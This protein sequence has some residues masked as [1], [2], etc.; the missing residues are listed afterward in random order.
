VLADELI[1]S[2]EA[3]VRNLLAGR[4]RLSR[5]GAKSP[6]V[7][8]CPDS[9][10]HPAVLP[11]I[12]RGFGFELIILWRGYGGA[13]WPAGDTVRWRAPDGESVTVYHLAR[14]G[15]ELGASLPPDA[16]TA[17][18]RW[19]EIEA[20]VGARATTSVVLLPNGADHHARQ[21][22]LDGALGAL[23]TA[24]PEHDI[25]SSSLNAFTSDLLTAA[26]SLPLP[27]IS[28]ELRDSS[29]YTWSL[30]G[31]FATR[32]AQKR[33]NAA[34][35][36]ALVREA[37]PFAAVD[38]LL[39]QRS[40]APIVRAAW[41]TLLEAHPHD[42]LCGCSIDEVA[43]AVD[44]LFASALAQATGVR[45]EAIAS[46]L[47]QDA[48]VARARP[49]AWTPSVIVRNG[50]PRAR[51]GVAVI[52]I[53]SKMADEPVGPGSSPPLDDPEVAARPRATVPGVLAIE[54]LG[55][56]MDRERLEFARHYP[57][58][59]RVSVTQAAAWVENVPG[60]GVRV[61]PI[62]ATRPR[63]GQVPNPVVSGAGVV[64]NG[65]VAVERSGEAITRIVH[66][67]PEAG[68]DLD[69]P[70]IVSAV[71]L[72]SASDRGDLYTPSIREP[73]V[74][75]DETSWKTLHRG[76]LLS[77][78]RVRWMVRKAGAP[79]RAVADTIASVTGCVALHADSPVVRIR[80][81]GEN[82]ARDHRL[83]IGFA[84][85]LSGAEVW[86]DAA[87]G[88]VRRLPD[89]PTSSG[90]P[91]EVRLSTAPLH[92]Y[93]SLFSGDRGVT[94]ISDGL[95]E[96]EVDTEG[97]LWVTLVRSVG[98]LSRSDIPERPG[99]AGWP[100]ATPDAQSIG[101]FEA[102]FAILGHGGRTAETIHLIEST[103][104]DVLVPL[105]GVTRRHA[106]APP[107]AVSGIELQGDGLAVSA[108]KQSESGD[109]VVLRCVNL[110]DV[111]VAGA[112]V[113]PRPVAGAWRAR[114]DET[115]T[116]PLDAVGPRVEFSAG[117]REIVTVIAR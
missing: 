14:P 66:R 109:A 13:H 65:L 59:D 2:G 72:E 81:G 5:A 95:A 34:A 99:H 82:T 68:V 111:P 6:P 88:P 61:Y 87:F 110:L 4:E 115:L 92:R 107:H 23:R 27:D 21:T 71:L 94:L 90:D 84:T 103:A 25:R 28:G 40:R 106:I 77:E 60:V 74:R 22:D 39:Q 62:G 45:D 117:P 51:T 16:A 89:A 48:D 19:A 24:A 38:W 97:T 114:L 42:T 93:V 8:Y 108:I 9:F 36:R 1:P 70:P 12:A 55:H 91:V 52:D 57:D 33:R 64:E 101:P 86:A 3:M 79:S 18:T 58:N 7:L 67:V 116:A 69:A 15:Y 50:L 11:T 29:G 32:A 73:R 98:E 78:A 35:E 112:W 30:Q 76:R 53:V 105:T 20:E 63:S 41:R 47:G 10:G 31:T 85:G 54:P 17:V 56:R 96:Y 104:D 26:S 113:L 102:R 83:R 46:V 49:D 44:V 75:V 80:I 43:R 100:A 37:E